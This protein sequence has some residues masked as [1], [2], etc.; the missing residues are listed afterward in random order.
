MRAL[1]QRV[2]RGAVRVEGRTVA[3]IGPGLVV[4][5]GVRH[6]DTEDEARFLARK[7]AHLRVFPDEQGKLNRSVLDVGGRVLSVSQFTL[8]GDCRKGNRPSFAEA[9]APEV[10]LPL[11]ETFNRALAEHGVPVQTGVFGA[12]MLVEI[13]NDGPVTIWLDTEGLRG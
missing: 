1:V 2:S 9:A 6:G 5:V 3:E 8:Y 12:V 4:L 13:L 10:A 7:V 11:F